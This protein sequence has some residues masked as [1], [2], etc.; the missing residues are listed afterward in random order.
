[1]ALERD[2][3]LRA[4]DRLLEGQAAGLE[5]LDRLPQLGE[6]GVERECGDVGI[7]GARRDQPGRSSRG[8][9]SSLSAQR[10]MRGATSIPRPN[11]RA[12]TSR[13]D[14]P[15][16]DELHQRSTVASISPSATRILSWVAGGAS[17]GRRT[18][19]S[20]AVRFTIA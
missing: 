2:R 19:A 17:A 12:R 8:S 18:I 4:A 11:P 7:D 16:D 5:L 13:G 1:M 20:S 15:D 10:P 9:S 14:Q 3:A 6:R